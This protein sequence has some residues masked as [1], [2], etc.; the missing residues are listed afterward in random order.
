MALKISFYAQFSKDLPGTLGV[1]VEFTKSII[2]IIGSRSLPNTTR[3]IIQA[4]D[5]DI[6][7]YCA[8]INAAYI[9]FIQPLVG[10][11][12]QMEIEK[13]TFEL[14]PD[15][16]PNSTNIAFIR[17][18]IIYEWVYSFWKI[19]DTNWNSLFSS[20][21]VFSTFSETSS[22]YD[23]IYN[24]IFKDIFELNIDTKTLLNK[25]EKTYG[26]KIVGLSSSGKG[27]YASNLLFEDDKNYEFTSLFPTGEFG[28]V[29]QGNFGSTKLG[30]TS[31]EEYYLTQVK[32]S[33]EWNRNDAYVLY[34]KGQDL[35]VEEQKFYSSSFV[36][37]NP[38]E[39][40][41]INIAAALVRKNSGYSAVT[42]YNKMVTALIE[43]A[44]VNISSKDFV[45]F[46]EDSE[47]FLYHVGPIVI[48]NIIQEDMI[49]RDFGYCYLVDN[50][51]SLIK[52]LPEVIIK[53][54]IID[55][56]LEKFFELKNSQVDS[57]ITY[58]KFMSIIKDSYKNL[59]DQAAATR[60]RITGEAQ[61]LNQYL[62]ENTGKFF[63]YRR[64]QVYRRFI[65]E[66]IW[67]PLSE[68]GNT[69]LL[70]RLVKK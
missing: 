66:T 35:K 70:N 38:A 4:Q 43:Y 52:F 15:L 28:T 61:S 58:S 69:D 47:V 25:I 48:W 50:K 44:M 22:L 49:R 21:K 39:N 63:G 18:K 57:Y 56:W 40:S 42:K 51:N 1:H 24:N 31:T 7:N 53:K 59:F 68:A 55:Y 14:F 37:L 26:C 67:A 34:I 17:M 33:K 64:A 3:D 10:Q 29:N 12:M 2:D 60:K 62:V 41:N 6:K 32:G 9:K 36:I 23:S 27:L 19:A 65:N 46:G 54:H 16:T 45:D 11:S 30:S 13:Q 20:I 5:T 8:S